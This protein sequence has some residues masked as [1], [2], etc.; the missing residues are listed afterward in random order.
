VPLCHQLQ[1]LRCI[2][3]SDVESDVWFG[4]DGNSAPYLTSGWSRPER[5]LT[6]SDGPES[7][8]VIYPRIGN[9]DYLVILRGRPYIRRPKVVLQQIEICGTGKHLITLIADDET[10]FV[11]WFQIRF[12]SKNGAPVHLTGQ[13]AR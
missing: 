11:S 10:L 7:T 3:V 12:F 1:G 6:W 4:A 5:D 8:I 9:A 13:S 2:R